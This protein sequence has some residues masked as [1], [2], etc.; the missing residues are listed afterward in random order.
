MLYSKRKKMQKKAPGVGKATDIGIVENQGVRAIKPHE[1][2]LL[3]V[4]ARLVF[5]GVYQI[6]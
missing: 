2:A 4:R 5:L 1:M 6:T 3:R